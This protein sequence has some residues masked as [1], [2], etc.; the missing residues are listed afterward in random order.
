MLLASGEQVTSAL[1]AGA[2]IKFGINSKS[3]LN[4]QIPILTEGENS[5]ARII[6]MN[7]ELDKIKMCI[8]YE[9]N[10]KKI[11][12]LPAASEDQFKIKPVYKTF[13]GW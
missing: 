9:L 5:N 7:I 10:G 11:D 4:W 13:P 2:L 12:Y 1:L 8:G 6:N 3:W